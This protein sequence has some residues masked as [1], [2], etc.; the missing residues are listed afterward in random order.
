[1]GGPLSRTL[2]FE[3]DPRGTFHAAPDQVE[4]STWSSDDL[5]VWVAYRMTGTGATPLDRQVH[6]SAQDLDVAFTGSGEVKASAQTT[7]TIK[8]DGLRVLPLALYPTLR[9]NAAFAESGMPLDFIQEAKEADAQFAIVLPQPAKRGDIV[10]ILTRYAGPG[11]VRRDGE[12]VYYLLPGARDRW[13]PAQSDDFGDFS[14]FHMTFH[15]PKHLQ[16]I[17]TGKQISLDAE[18]GGTRAVWATDSPIPVAGFNLGDFRS[19]SATT[20]RGFHITAFANTSLP[21]YAS[22]LPEEGEILGNMSTIP[23]LKSEVSQGTAAIQIYTDFFGKLP[24]DH[25]ALTQQSACNYGQSWPML[26][27]LPTCAFWDSTVQHYLG[28]LDQDRGYW[29]QVTAH[30]VSHQWWGNLIGFSSYRD[31]WMSEGFANFSV[32]VYLLSTSSNMNGYRDF[33]TQQRNNILRKNAQGVRPIDVGPLTMGV[34]TANDKTGDVYQDLIYSKGAFV[35]HMLEMMC[36]TPAQGESVFRRSMQQFVADYS[37]KSATTEDFKASLEK[38]MPPALDINR[39]GKLDWFFDEYVYGTEL[40]RYTLSSEFTTTPEG[41]STVHL[42]LAQ[43]NVS[44]K[45]VMIVP[46]YLQLEN[47]S[48]VRMAN[49]TLRGNGSF[50]HVFQLG[51]LTVKPKRVLLNYNSDVLSEQL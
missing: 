3:V 46:I 19:S 36:W 25:V 8:E 9:V 12:G 7:L 24:Y 6:I 11:A 43:G 18:A 44:D 17:A 21:D 33:W 38:T 1:M 41:E 40:P 31:Q 16:I 49:V 30:E 13:Y 35:L 20:P 22:R 26:V 42:K 34:R 32:G 39:N 50:D 37:G 28:L 14:S 10:R 47:G 4:L 15:L 48:T 2:V 27:Y 23:M 5:N 51:K 29:D 45:F